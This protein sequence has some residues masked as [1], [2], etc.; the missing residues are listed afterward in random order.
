[1]DYW[2]Y[3]L[4]S[5]STGHFY[6]GQTQDLADR[7]RRHA[8]GRVAATRGRGPWRLVYSERVSTRSAAVARERQ[9]KARKSR[10]F[11]LGLRDGGSGG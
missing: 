3:V 9:I 8:E 11:I 4:E 2:V 5:T 6:V 7:V 10:N 1:M